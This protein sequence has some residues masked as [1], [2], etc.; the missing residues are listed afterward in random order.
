MKQENIEITG[1]KLGKKTKSMNYYNKLD[2]KNYKI[3]DIEYAHPDLQTAT[4]GLVKHLAKAYRI[5]GEERD[6]FVVD[7]FT[8]DTKDKHKTIIIGGGMSNEY[9]YMTPIKS[10]HIPLD[11]SQDDL[12]MDIETFGV[13]LFRY[14]FEGKMAQGTLENFPTTPEQEDE[15]T[16]KE[17]RP[18]G[19]EV[20]DNSVEDL[21]TSIETDS[22][23]N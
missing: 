20:S 14:F 15:M 16:E 2:H 10:G 19:E 18:E 4:E 5:V 11:E 3:E 12:K 6:Y 7:G 8:L 17:D 22:G 1:C 21:L 13:E 9:G 23:K